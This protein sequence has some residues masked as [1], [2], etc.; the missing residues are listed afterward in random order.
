MAKCFK[1][2]KELNEIKS[3]KYNEN[4]IEKVVQIIKKLPEKYQSFD[5]PHP[6]KAV[7]RE[8]SFHLVF[9]HLPSQFL[10]H[11]EVCHIFYK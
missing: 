6:P 2:I 11:S 7:I 9:T 4:N 8:E 10:K 5:G 3:M 1:A